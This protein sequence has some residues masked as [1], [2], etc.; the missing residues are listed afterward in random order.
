MIILRL[1][2]ERVVDFLLVLIELFGRLGVTAEVLRANIGSKS[3]ISLQR[4]PVDPKF[5][6]S[7]HSVTFRP[8]QFTLLIW[9]LHV[10]SQCRS[11]WVADATGKDDRGRAQLYEFMR[12]ALAQARAEVQEKFVGSVQKRVLSVVGRSHRLWPRTRQC[13]YY[14]YKN[15]TRSTQ[16]W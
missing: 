9:P 12:Y 1:N 13:Y 5:T 4:G 6:A 16:L 3:A 10:G 2:G 11:H 8:T 7:A 15:R 14:Y